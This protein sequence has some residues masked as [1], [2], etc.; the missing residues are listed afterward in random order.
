M[1][2]D[3]PEHTLFEGQV[4]PQSSIY[5]ASEF[6][7]VPDCVSPEIAARWQR[8]RRYERCVRADIGH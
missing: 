8:F 7:G 1:A 2:A 3:A 6:S 4:P 5:E